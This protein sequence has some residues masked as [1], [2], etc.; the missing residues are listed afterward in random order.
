M[1]QAEL[2][3]MRRII[4]ELVTMLPEEAK[5]TQ[6]V[7]ELAGWG[8]TTTMHLVE[9]NAQPIAG[10]NNSRDFDFSRAAVQARWR[11]GYVDACRTLERRP[12]DDPIDPATHVTVYQSDAP[13]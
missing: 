4:R 7:K 2:H 10:E 9:I 5:E 12:W 1:R 6:R 11:A 8:C 3:R 13:T